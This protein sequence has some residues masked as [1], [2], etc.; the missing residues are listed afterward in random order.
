MTVLSNSG[1]PYQ[2]KGSSHEATTNIEAEVFQPT[3]LENYGPL[4][5]VNTVE[6][7]LPAFAGELQPGL[8]RTPKFRKFANPAPL[9]LSGFAL[10]TFVLGCINMGTRDITE[11]NMVVG[12]A[13]AYGGLVQLLAGMWE[14]AAGNTFGATALSSYGGFWIALGITFTP[15]FQIM[16]ELQKAD[17]GS[18]DMFYDSFGLFLMGWFAFTFLLLTCT[19]KST[20]VF[21]SL[22]LSVDVAFLLLGIGHLHR[23]AQGKPNQSVLTAGGLFALLAAFLA[24][25]SALAG[26][27]DD[28]NSF[29]I[30][31]VF[32]FPWSEKGRASRHEASTAV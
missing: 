14:M 23:D 12:V 20:A 25:Y 16:S 11:P 31:P 15:G 10:A 32:H 19:V 9:G 5:H 3:H 29:F 28:S 4:A 18:T 2:E 1:N 7:R 26:I 30:I 17:N 24:W 22:F 21:F 13:Y 6:S 27:A 8:Y